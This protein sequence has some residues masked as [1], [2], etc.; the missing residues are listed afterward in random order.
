MIAYLPEI[1]PDE[2]VYSWL[3]RYYIKTGYVRYVFV[4]EELFQKKTVRP[5]I[6]FV[7][8]YTAPTLQSI[9]EKIPMQRIIEQH[10]MF[11][12][13]GRFLQKER[14][15]QAFTALMQTEGNYHNLLPMPKRKGNTERYLRYCPV[16]AERDREQRGETYWHRI[17]QLQGVNICPIHK[18]Y[19]INSAVR[20]SGKASPIL[21]TAETCIPENKND[22]VICQNNIE[23]KTAAYVTEVFQSELDLNCDITVG[24]F[25]HSRMENTPYRSVRGQQ[26]NIAL[27][28]ADFQEYYKNLQDNSFSELWQIQKV[29]TDDRVNSYEICLLAMFLNISVKDL[30]KMELPERTQ[31]QRFDEQIYLLHE[32]G[33][34][35]PAIA[36]RLGASYDTVKAIGEQRYKKYHKYHK[37]SGKALKCGTKAYNWQ[38]IDK[39]T[40]PLVRDAIVQLQ[41]T[42]NDRPKKVTVFAVEKLLQLPSKRIASYLPKCKAEIEK[43]YETQE[44]YWAREVVWAVNYILREGNTLNWKHIRNLTNM[45]KQDLMKCV[46]YLLNYVDM[47][48]VDKIKILI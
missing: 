28:H 14:R 29:L 20:I 35:Y 31:E 5:D 38:Q 27:L 44:E 48:M 16:C 7:N 22:I 45:R 40:L 26:R 43:H 12:Y 8:Q 33:L 21:V 3:A 13:Y 34:K 18:C 1:Y 23:C 25:L 11:P 30:I 47:D 9:T 37:E 2:L 17:H 15:N 4:A 36:K 42:E 41:G 46:P 32:Q 19:L 39:D 24:N 10:T 6:E